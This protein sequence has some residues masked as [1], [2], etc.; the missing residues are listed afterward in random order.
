MQGSR[1][2]V[3]IIFIY[4][5]YLFIFGARRQTR[6][7]VD[8]ACL[9][10]AGGGKRV[11]ASECARSRLA[12]TF[13]CHPVT[14]SHWIRLFLFFLSPVSKNVLKI[15]FFLSSLHVCCTMDAEEA[16]ALLADSR[17]GGGRRWRR[18]VHRA[19]AVTCEFLHLRSRS[20]SLLSPAL[21]RLIRHFL[22]F[23]LLRLR[24]SAAL[25]AGRRAAPL[26]TMENLE[27]CTDSTRKR[28]GRA[29]MRAC[30]RACVRMP[31]EVY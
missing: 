3:F 16:A 23:D 13:N 7:R 24:P 25:A 28:D 29:Y 17:G 19:A 4:F 15:F 1:R 10:A 18:G 26:Q 9:A 12:H 2:V 21:F 14:H 20:L 31:V 8:L 30:V 11:C 5:S 22:C 27:F 6:L